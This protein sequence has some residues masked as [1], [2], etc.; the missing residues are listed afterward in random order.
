MNTPL[1]IETAKG[2]ELGWYLATCNKCEVEPRYLLWSSRREAYYTIPL[3]RSCEAQ[4]QKAKRSK[5]KV[6]TE[7]IETE[8][9]TVVKGVAAKTQDRLYDAGIYTVAALAN[10]TVADLEGVGPAARMVRLIEAA[11]ETV[12]EAGE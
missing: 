11:K 2:E 1:P 8:D 3:C 7:V 5:V 4:R 6:T 12:A 9:L 10:A